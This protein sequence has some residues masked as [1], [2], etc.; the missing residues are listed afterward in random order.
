M[1]YHN[2]TMALYASFYAKAKKMSMRLLVASV[3]SETSI[4]RPGFKWSSSSLTF[5]SALINDPQVYW[6]R[7]NKSGWHITKQRIHTSVL[8]LDPHVEC[9]VRIQII[10]QP[11]SMT[12]FHDDPKGKHAPQ[13]K[14][15]INI[16]LHSRSSLG[17]N[18]L[19]TG[20]AFMYMA[21]S[22]LRS[23]D[24]LDS[25]DHKSHF[26]LEKKKAIWCLSKGVQKSLGLREL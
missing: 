2:T 6:D 22:H 10:T 20:D 1:T 3:V 18:G 19:T 12:L 5:L 25:S 16:Y 23:W 17:A 24:A 13:C 4:T 15:L 7:M 11:C 14:F 26:V 21:A 8:L 9:V